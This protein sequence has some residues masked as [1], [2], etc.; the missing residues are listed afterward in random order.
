MDGHSQMGLGHLMRCLALAQHLQAEDIDVTFAVLPGTVPFCRAR[1][2]WVGAVLTI[3]E[4]LTQQDE[5]AWLNQQPAFQQADIVVLDGYQFNEIYRQALKQTGCQLALFDDNNNSG[6]LHADLV[7]NGAANA[8]QLGYNLS[9][10]GAKY[11]LG[12]KFRVLRREFTYA[13]TSWAKRNSLLI[14]MG[15]SDPANLT[16]PL[17]KALDSAGADMPI[18]VIT[19]AAYPWL[20]QLQAFWAKTNLVVQHI[21]DCQQMADAYCHAKLVVSAA[22][23]SQY[24]LQATAS[25]AFLLVVADNQAEATFYTAGQHWCRAVDCRQRVDFVALTQ[26]VLALWQDKQAL[27][28]MHTKAMHLADLD[29]ASRIITT[30]MRL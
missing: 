8:E 26:Q 7:I 4:G 28:S 19:G 20:G 11:C 22:G 27:Q 1:H 25:P 9:A 16:L 17:L 2:D 13:E 14:T 12:E 21:Q 15:G 10:P 29:G 18:R 30:M 3:P 5:I 23:G 24:E 6:M